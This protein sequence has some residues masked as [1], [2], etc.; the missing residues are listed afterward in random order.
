MEVIQVILTASITS[1]VITALLTWILRIKDRDELRRWEIKREACLE[2]LRIIDC[3]FADYEWRDNQGN[4]VKT[5]T[6]GF[7]PTA[8]IRSCFN[9]LVLACETPEVPESFAECLDLNLGEANQ[10]PL[11]MTKVVDLRNKI[12]AELGFGEA[13]EIKLAWITKINWK[14]SG[15]NQA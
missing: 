15:N 1:G 14:K 13:H 7:I 11:N 10:T 4:E 8:D 2:A 3:R 6:Q 5:D 9:K 12:R